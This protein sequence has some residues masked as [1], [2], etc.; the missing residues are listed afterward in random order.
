MKKVSRLKQISLG[1]GQGADAANR[2]LVLKVAVGDSKKPLA[3][4]H[5][6]YHNRRTP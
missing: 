1:Q 2:P 5:L 6:T 4:K 3:H